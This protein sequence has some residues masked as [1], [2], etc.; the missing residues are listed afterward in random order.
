MVLVVLSSG[1]L[2]S[3]GSANLTSTYIGYGSGSNTLTGDAN[4]TYT[5]ASSAVVLD[6]GYL[7]FTGHKDYGSAV[8]GSIFKPRIS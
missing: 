5:S 3:N 8:N 6:S 4:L 2:S 1:T 7:S